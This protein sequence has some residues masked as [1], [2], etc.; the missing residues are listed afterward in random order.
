MRKIERDIPF[1]NTEKKTEEIRT[2]R[3]S[4]HQDIINE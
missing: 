2:G 1:N 4:T 3:K